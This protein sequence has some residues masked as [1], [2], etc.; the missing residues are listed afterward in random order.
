MEKPLVKR[1]PGP[2]GLLHWSLVLGKHN[3]HYICPR[4]DIAKSHCGLSGEPVTGEMANVTRKADR[5]WLYQFLDGIVLYMY[6]LF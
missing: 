2:L 5:K 3:V 1:G 4:S 6:I